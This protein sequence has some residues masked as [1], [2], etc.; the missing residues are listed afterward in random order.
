M[1]GLRIIS[2]G[3]NVQRFIY[4]QSFEAKRL[5]IDKI[6]LKL[7]VEEL[8]GAYLSIKRV[9]V[10]TLFIKLAIPSKFHWKMASLVFFSKFIEATGSYRTGANSFGKITT[11]K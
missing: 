1:L 3:N 10:K 11:N 9:F 7:Y 6:S 4:P 2:N 5:K 8:N